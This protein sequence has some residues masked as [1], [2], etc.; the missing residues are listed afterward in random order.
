MRSPRAAI[1]G[2]CS[3]V[4][5]DHKARSP[6]RTARV[7]LGQLI[8]EGLLASGTPKGPVSLRFPASSLDLLFP[9]LFPAT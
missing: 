6:E 4:D 2:E 7:V 3:C 5:A 8:D 9:Q 1:S